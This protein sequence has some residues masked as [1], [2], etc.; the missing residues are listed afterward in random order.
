MGR[1]Y[2]R[3]RGAILV[4][5]LLGLLAALT[6]TF[7]AEAQTEPTEVGLAAFQDGRWYLYE[8]GAEFPSARFAFGTPWHQPL[9]GDWDCDGIDTVGAFGGGRV[10]LRNTNTAGPE[11][12][13]F[14]FGQ[15]TD[16][17]LPGDWDGDGCD[18]IGVYRPT[19]GLVF[20]RNELTTGPADETYYFGDPGDRPFAADFT[21]S[22]FDSVGLYREATGL[23]YLRESPSTGVADF[24]FFYGDPADQFIGGDWDGDGIETVG[25][26]RSADRT[27]YLRNENTQGFADSSYPLAHRRIHHAQR[28]ASSR[29]VPDPKLV[30]TAAHQP[31]GRLLRKPPGARHG[32]SG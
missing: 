13:A 9:M 19:Q 14:F 31:G 29:W 23:V 6:P 21:G 5:L 10:S 26:V 27:V 32:R 25:I 1:T 7:E 17:A 20:L 11:E 4:V 24:E 22:G 15:P 8:S 18:S 28:H 2:K 3:R 30:P 16:I 12:L